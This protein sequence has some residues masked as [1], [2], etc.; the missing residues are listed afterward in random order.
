ML[1]DVRDLCVEYLGGG[2]AYRAVD[3]VSFTIGRG[4][5]HALVGES[6]CGKTSTALSIPQLLGSGGEIRGGQILFDG[7]DLVRAKKSELRSLRGRHIANIFQEPTTALNPVLT[8]GEQLRETIQTHRGVGRREAGA[9]GQHWLE[10]VE[11]PHANDR[12]SAYPHELSG[13]MNQRVM[14]A[15]ALA[16]GPD[17]LIADE[18]TTAL[19]VTVERRILKLLVGLVKELSIGVLLITHD[20]PLA[21]QISDQI[22]VM[23]SA[24]IVEQG[25]TSKVLSD[26]QH[27]HSRRLIQATPKL[28][29]TEERPPD[30]PSA[31]KETAPSPALLEFDSVRKSFALRGRNAQDVVALDDVSL[32][33]APGE[34]LGLVGETGSGKTTLGRCAVRLL[35]PD[36]GQVRFEGTDLGSLSSQ[37]LRRHR[38]KFQMIFQNV[39][40]ALNPRQN[41]RK[42]VGE[43]LDLRGQ[44]SPSE[45]DDLV[46]NALERVGLSAGDVSRFPH[47]FSGGERQRLGIARAIVLRPAL[48]VCDE[49]VSSLDVTIQSQ[50]LELLRELRAEFR[51]TYLFISHDLRVVR[52]FCDRVAVLRD[53]RLLE[54]APTE[55]VF[56][57]PAHEY[58]RELI[59]AA[60]RDLRSDLG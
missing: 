20:L 48:I 3:G 50:I 11:I 58:T 12:M 52:H 15:M 7:N 54:V 16:C 40:G 29:A 5:I 26:A 59:R 39:T 37:E 44:G 6:G 18:P 35:E 2:S 41:V 45:R 56:R 23:N 8:I 9:Q 31:A 10:R 55:E 22:S 46:R 13:G 42:I 14:I 49:P 34:T 19:D 4:E 28:E 33:I 17:L 57:S 24:Q 38:A 27:P 1:L 43:G 32:T 60:R 21:A 25:V 51:L 53:G 47:E 30:E 36:A